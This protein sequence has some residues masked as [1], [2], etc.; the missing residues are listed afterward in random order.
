MKTGTTAIPQL[1][2]LAQLLSAAANFTI[3]SDTSV[4]PVLRQ[5][6]T[7]I[8]PVS[9]Q[10]G[11]QIAAFSHLSYNLAQLLTICIKTVLMNIK[12]GILNQ[13]DFYYIFMVPLSNPNSQT[14]QEE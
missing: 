1:C 12:R 2:F 5:C 7:S 14:H 8:A 13:L 11:W 10:H 4:A 6:R 3:L 9:D